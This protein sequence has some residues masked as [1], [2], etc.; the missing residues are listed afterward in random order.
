MRFVSEF[1]KLIRF[2]KKEINRNTLIF[3]VFFCIAS[4]FWI[5]N[6]L[7][8]T[9]TVQIPI[10]LEYT[11]I[12]KTKA[13][14][15]SAPDTVNT[16]VS[17]TG[18]ALLRFYMYSSKTVD[19]HIEQL[20]QTQSNSDSVLRVV[21][22]PLIQSSGIFSNTI[23]VNKVVPKIV[24][25]AFAPIHKKKVK[26]VAKYSIE[27]T[28]QYQ[29]QHNPT[30][31][32]DSVFLYGASELLQTIDSVYTTE[33]FAQ[34][35]SQSFSRKIQ[36][37][38]IRNVQLS[39]TVVTVNVDIEKFTEQQFT[40]PITAIHV[41]DT[42]LIDLMNHSVQITMFTGMSHIQKNSPQDFK[43]IADFTKQNTQTGEIP[44]EIIA[45][46]KWGRIVKITPEFVGYIIESK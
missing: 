45:R 15:T 17:A 20:L 16:E 24:Q 27:C 14:V 41:P 40:I 3:G 23:T 44:I 36:L 5:I 12:P 22:Q 13:I 39:D 42:V 18:Y 34:D 4:L 9:Y 2:V 38:A 32:P 33:I 31:I 10:H 30:T 8:K 26:V 43:V 46:P 7:Q 28:Q 6:A 25:F 35:V 11:H 29:L 21:L 1:A 37:Q 19:I